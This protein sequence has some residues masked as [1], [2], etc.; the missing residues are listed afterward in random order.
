M[1]P[2]MRLIICHRPFRKWL[3]K[4]TNLLGAYMCPTSWTNLWH[5]CTLQ[6]KHRGHSMPNATWITNLSDEKRTFYDKGIGKNIDSSFWISLCLAATIAC[7]LSGA[8]PSTITIWIYFKS[9]SSMVMCTMQEKCINY[10]N[11]RTS[12]NA[13]HLDILSFLYHS[14]ET[15]KLS[16]HISFI[17]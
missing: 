15:D 2:L 3:N 7:G 1:F 5:V 6:W 17:I 10:C 14:E 13:R 4:W 9:H 8:K 11:A 16:I 12:E